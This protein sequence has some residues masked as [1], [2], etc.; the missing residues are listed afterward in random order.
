MLSFDSAHLSWLRRS[1]S[2]EVRFKEGKLTDTRAA[3][4]NS[5]TLHLTE[6]QT[7]N[8][9][10]T[11]RTFGGL[12]VLGRENDRLFPIVALRVSLKSHHKALFELNDCSI[13]VSWLVAFLRYNSDE[14][15]HGKIP[16]SQ[17]SGS[18]VS[19]YR[20]QVQVIYK[21]KLSHSY[22]IFDLSQT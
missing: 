18:G 10:S 12:G 20:N 16:F 5:L 8:T 22:T 11:G 17:W 13:H 15:L 7:E 14:L 19:F 3:A 9:S 2:L 21:F 1:L 4:L 6:N